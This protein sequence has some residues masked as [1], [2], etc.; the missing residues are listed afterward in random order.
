MRAILFPF[1]TKVC[2]AFCGEAKQN[3]QAI[4]KRL[5]IAPSFLFLASFS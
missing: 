3:E 5:I 1:V 2:V 4:N